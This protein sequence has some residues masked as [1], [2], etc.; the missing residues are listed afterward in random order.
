MGAILTNDFT[1]KGNSSQN[2]LP[3]K[4]ILRKQCWYTCN[5]LAWIPSGCD[6]PVG[7]KLEPSIDSSP[8]VNPSVTPDKVH[9]S[10]FAFLDP[11]VEPEQEEFSLSHYVLTN[12]IEEHANGMARTTFSTKKRVEQEWIQ[13]TLPGYGY[14]ARMQ[15]TSTCVPSSAV[16][17][18][19]TI[20]KKTL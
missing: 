2:N 10:E 3:I 16:V 15:S 4:F 20:E 17:H 18:S 9:L 8:G 11:S 1:L 19:R 6:K 13:L 7:V 5:N 12:M 14:T